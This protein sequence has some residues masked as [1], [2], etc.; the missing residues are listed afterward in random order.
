[1]RKLLEQELDQVKKAIAVKD[2]TSAEILIEVYDHY[3]SHLESKTTEN[4]DKELFELEQKFTYGYCHEVQEK[5]VKLSK[6]EI[7]NL[8][9][10]IFKTYFSWPKI[11]LTAVFV[12][13]LILLWGNIDPRTQ[14]L[15]IIVLTIVCILFTLGLYINSY[16]KVRLIKKIVRSSKII[17]SSYLGAIML[18]GMMMQS[19]FHIL[20]FGTNLWI[21]DITKSDF[22]GAISLSI[23]FI[24]FS[25]TLTLIQAWKIKSKTALI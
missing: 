7:F 23:F 2:L 11:L 22:F 8:Q 21:P 15:S 14:T 20:I 1:M 4:F 12:P 25:L 24:Y 17:E 10:S 3:V 19:F 9:W 18:Q 5:L 16:R 13:I 6:K